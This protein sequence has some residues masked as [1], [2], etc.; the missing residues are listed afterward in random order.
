MMSG[1][2]NASREAIIQVAIIGDNKQL[3][4]VRAAGRTHTFLNTLYLVNL[5][6]GNTKVKSRY[7]Q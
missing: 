3:R 1:R 7:S 4:S 2:V 6:F 5:D